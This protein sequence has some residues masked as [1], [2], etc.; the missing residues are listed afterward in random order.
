M[1]V[2]VAPTKELV[3]KI[4]QNCDVF[5]KLCDVKFCCVQ[6]NVDWALNDLLKVYN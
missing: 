3:V 5:S 4:S 1:A 6:G 2:I